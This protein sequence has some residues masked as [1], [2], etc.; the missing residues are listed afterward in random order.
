MDTKDYSAQRQRLVERVA[1]D[2]NLDGFDFR[3]LLYLLYRLDFGN[4]LE[5]EQREIVAALG[6][7]KT[8]VSRS[9]AKLKRIGII[10][11]GMPRIGLYRKYIF[12]PEYLSD[13]YQARHLKQGRGKALAKHGGG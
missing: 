8:H 1:K 3:V 6:K 11:E 7:H 2:D 4:F 9:I 10:V 13:S 12:N 5:I